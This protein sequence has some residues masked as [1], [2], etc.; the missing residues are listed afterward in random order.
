MIGSVV[1]AACAAYGWPMLNPQPLG[2]SN[3]GRY[4]FC[5]PLLLWAHSPARYAS[6][7]AQPSVH[8]DAPAQGSGVLTVLMFFGSILSPEQAA[9]YYVASWPVSAC[10]QPVWPAWW[11]Q[12]AASRDHSQLLA[13]GSSHK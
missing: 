7:G 3:T 4:G 13:C 1:L 5:S 11:R 10:V 8:A 6:A 2:C 9:D 12:G